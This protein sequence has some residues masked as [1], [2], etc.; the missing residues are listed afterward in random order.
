MANRRFE[1]FEYRQVL[2]RMRL[3]SERGWSDVTIEGC[4]RTV[5]RFFV[6]LDERGVDLA[7]VRITMIDQVTARYHAR[8]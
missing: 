7:S 3:S 6:W 2:T 4:C 1:M 5:N 8:G